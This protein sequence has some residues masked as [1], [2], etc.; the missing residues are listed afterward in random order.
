MNAMKVTPA[1]LVI[2]D[3][4]GYREDGADNAIARAHKPNWDRLWAQYPHSTI[5]ASEL[6]V[7]LPPEQMGNSEVGHLNIGAGRVVF[8]EFTRIELAIRNGELGTNEVLAKAVR[9]ARERGSAL[10]VLGLVS[11]GGVHSHQDQI[12]ALIDMAAAQGAPAIHVHAFLDGRDTPPKSA[13]ESLR[14]LEGRCA[15]HPGCRIA[16][17]CGRYYAMDRDQRWER[18]A[19]AYRLLT[20]ALA[21]FEADSA[22]AGLDAAYAR[23]ESDEFVQPTAIRAPRAA[24]RGMDDGDVVVFMNFRADRARQLTR[25][26]TDPAFDGFERAKRPQLA[27]YCT[28]TSYGEEFELPVAFAPQRVEQGFGEYIAGLGLRQLRIAETEKYAHVTY[29]FNGGVETPYPGEERILVPSPKVATY[30]LKPEMSAFEVTDKLEQAIRSQRFHAI[31]C[32]YANADMVGHT[33]NLEAA[34]RAIEALDPCIGR[35]VEAM[36]ET[37]GE[38]LVTADHGNAETMQDP[39]TR[40]AHTAHTTNRVPLLYVGRKAVLA[41]SGALSDIA[42]SLLAMMGLAQPAAMTGQSLIRFT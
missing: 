3:G 19:P 9:T 33:G 42:P 7:G 38:V 13:A 26:L 4:F 6:H 14:A 16:S 17:I 5:D 15:A 30:D 40:Q 11:P 10:H 24:A 32:N 8:Q 39:R 37:G 29:F 36:R 34:T 21:P 18:T 25:A 23:G 1:L 35:V 20:E 2:L 27:C 31:V 28:L 12:F 22:L 41:P